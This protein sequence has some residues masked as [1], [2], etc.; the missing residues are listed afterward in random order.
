MKRVG[1]IVLAAGASQRLGAPKQLARL[2]GETLVRR[3]ARAA[4]ASRC[5][6]TCVVVG[7]AA[8][9]VRAALAG[10]DLRIAECTDWPE[11]I[12]ASMRAGL[13][14]LDP[15]MD[16]ALFLLA[17]QPQV[18]AE[19]LD[20]LLAAFEAKGIERAGCAYAGSVGVPA[21]FGRRWF[22]ALRALRG[23]RGARGLLDAPGAD[24]ALLDTGK[25]LA[26]LDTPE[27]AA[28]LGVT[29]PLP[30]EVLDHLGGH[31][32]SFLFSL[33]RDGSPTAHPMTALVNAGAL[34]FTTYRKSAK[35]RNLERDARA[36]ALLL[37]GYASDARGW[38]R[39]FEVRGRAEIRRTEGLPKAVAR[40]EMGATSRAVSER[41]DARMK[42]GR[43][44][45]IELC[46]PRLRALSKPPGA[47]GEPQASEA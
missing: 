28:A 33:R 29:L 27:A 9:H 45:E 7:S 2:G 16:G 44:V 15:G 18:D 41:V 26:D 3:A 32:R 40:P 13:D 25:P 20:D 1:A 23:D 46:E 6:A 35:A 21:V 22:E 8:L 17:D 10:L 11:G 38:P 4:L 43:R 5:A 42:E 37:D 39:G 36:C 14:A 19:L 24:R 34:V 47:R 30:G 12:S 31:A